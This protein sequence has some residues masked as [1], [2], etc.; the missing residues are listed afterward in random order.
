MLRQRVI[1]A[2]VMLALFL[3]TI[4]YAPPQPFAALVLALISAGAWEWAKLNGIQSNMALGVGVLCALIC[5]AAWYAGALEN[6]SR[7]RS[8]WLAVGLFWVLASAALL[9]VGAAAWFKVPQFVRLVIGFLM[10]FLAWLAVAQAKVLGTNLLLSILLLVWAADIF[11]YFAGKGF[12]GRFTKSKLAPSISPG[13]SW[14]GVWGGTLGV[15]VLAL[16]WQWADQ[17]FG[18]TVPSQFGLWFK[19]GWIFFLV[20][21]LFMTAMSVV[22]DLVESLVKRSAGAKDSSNLLPGH[23]GVLDRVDALLPVLPLAM[24]LY[25][26]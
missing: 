13:K 17:Y 5:T 18:A 1:T 24:A 6:P 12:G 9:K 8:L 16:C 10:I 25:L 19:K 3:P 23:G 4:F 2:L 11:A 20:A 21:T 14:E 22:G 15:L 26:Y 7:F